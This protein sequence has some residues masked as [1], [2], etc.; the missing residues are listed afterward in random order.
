MGLFWNQQN[1]QTLCKG[2]FLTISVLKRQ[3]TWN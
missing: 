2:L 3:K 1:F